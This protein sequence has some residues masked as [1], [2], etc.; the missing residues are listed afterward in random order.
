MNVQAADLAM[1]GKNTTSYGF[2]NFFYDPQTRTATWTLTT[3]LAKERLLLDL[4]G[5]GIHPVTNFENVVLDGEWS[6]NTDTFA[7]G[8]GTAG[9]DFEFLL[10]VLPA[11]ANTSGQVTNFDYL[12]I[13]SQ[14]GKSTTSTGYNSKYDLDGSG[15]INST[16]W[17]FALTKVA[18]SLPTGNPVGLANDAPTTSGFGL[19]SITNS[20]IDVAIS[21]W[22][23]FGDVESGASGLTYSI[24]NNSAPSLFDSVSINTT[25]GQLVV[26][27]ASGVSGRANIEINATDPSGLTTRGRVPIDVNRVNLPPSIIHQEPQYQGGYTW[28]FK[29]TVTDPDDDVTGLLVD[30]YGV[31]EIRAAVDPDGT[32]EFAI[33]LFGNPYGEEHAVVCDW[34]GAESEIE[35]MEVGFT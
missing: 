14:D 16:D 29:G 35:D 32:F 25:T 8:N 13:R 18:D 23:K 24:A 7:S 22:S 10:N 1:S 15:V 20:A 34:H 26:N 3:S 31:F 33:I 5:N 19:T 2:T 4:D 27:A 6:N 12:M 9:G 21:L 28:L 30:Y 17:Q 11:D